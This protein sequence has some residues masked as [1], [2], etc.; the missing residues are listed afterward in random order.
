MRRKENYWN[1]K[2]FRLAETAGITEAIG[3][4]DTDFNDFILNENQ[5]SP[6]NRA[7]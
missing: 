2:E 5:G 3:N 4:L 1:W 7:S 6:T